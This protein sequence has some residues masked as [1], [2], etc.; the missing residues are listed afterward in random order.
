[1]GMPNTEVRVPRG[2]K[3]LHKSAVT[4]K[5]IMI[6]T[7]RSVRASDSIFDATQM[8]CKNGFSGAPVLD[9]AGHLK[10]I[11]SEKD[12]IHAFLN[13]IHHRSPPVTVQEVM[14]ANVITVTE[15][16]GILD[17]AHLFVDKGLRRV[18]VTRE[19]L[20][21]GQIS[22]RDLLRQILQIFE[23]SIIKE[24]IQLK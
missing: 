16:T 7:V 5:D 23:A 15:D 20:L 13:A 10:G 6:T 17:V 1:M 3:M 24:E 18:P 14:T 4:A 2:G 21:V 8:L 22:R 9:G 19:G 12:C 11:L